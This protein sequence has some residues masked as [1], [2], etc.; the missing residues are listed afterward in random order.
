MGV[1][2]LDIAFVHDISSDNKLLPTSWK[3]QFEIALEGAF[4]ALSRMREE[5]IIKGWGVGVNTPDPI[6]RV[7]QEFR[8]GRVPTCL[9]IF[10]DQDVGISPRLCAIGLADGIVLRIPLCM[11]LSHPGRTFSG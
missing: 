9:A 2:R 8:S 1:S 4:S 6:L 7:M 11:Q 3:E 10:A 5:G